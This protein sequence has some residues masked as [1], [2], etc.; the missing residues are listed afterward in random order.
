MK[1]PSNIFW[2][3]PISFERIVGVLQILQAKGSLKSYAFDAEG[4]KTGV[5]VGAKN[6]PFA[7]STNSSY[8]RIMQKLGLITF[9]HRQYSLAKT[10]LVQE[11]LV[12]AVPWPQPLNTKSEVLL[13]EIITTNIDCWQTFF[14]FLA[15][16]IT[17]S[18]QELRAKGNALIISVEPMSK[19]TKQAKATKTLIPK[20]LLKPAGKQEIIL[21]TKTSIKA[22]VGG[23]RLWAS[24]LGIT[25]EIRL[26]S[27][28]G[29]VIAPLRQDLT[30]EQIEQQLW[31]TLLK[32]T[33]WETGSEWGMCYVPNLVRAMLVEAHI[34]ADAT[35][36]AYHHLMGVAQRYLIAVPTT[37]AFIVI[38]TQYWK[39]EPA[40]YKTYFRSNKG[41]YISH[42]RV[43]RKALTLSL[44]E[45]KISV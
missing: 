13:A 24:K 7:K 43:S 18:L 1:K 45:L 16:G 30:P 23:L 33:T 40:F 41:P 9:E 19:K 35:Q 8:R 5:F 2:M 3:C 4:R 42:L 31:Q 27:K 38:K 34:S 32:Q 12:V 39:Q 10:A 26:D 36:Q 25:D 14:R 44:E 6:K 21:T 11:L 17:A 15:P 29:L 20:V 22:I 28:E 37:S